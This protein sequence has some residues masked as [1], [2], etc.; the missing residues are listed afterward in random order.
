MDHEQT[1]VDDWVAVTPEPGES[2]MI[3][4]H[5]L[6]TWPSSAT[7]DEIHRTLKTACQNACDAISRKLKAA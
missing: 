6:C 3:T 4:A 5:L 7:E 2:R 1:R